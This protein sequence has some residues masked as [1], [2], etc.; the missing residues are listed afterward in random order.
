MTT[1]A[2][3][4]RARPHDAPMPTE[5]LLDDAA[6]ELDRLATLE[7]AVRKVIDLVNVYL[8]PDSKMSDRDFISEVIGA[9]DNATIFE[10]LKGS[11]NANRD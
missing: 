8:P 5:Y 10:A 4:I 2:E 9:V 3:R 11:K 7:A 6:D 1:L